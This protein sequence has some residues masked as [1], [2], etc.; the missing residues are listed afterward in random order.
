MLI[1]SFK[2]VKL[3]FVAATALAVA[4]F[5]ALSFGHTASYAQ[6]G[7]AIEMKFGNYAFEPATVTVPAGAVN[8]NINNPDSRRHDIV[9]VVNGEELASEIIESGAAGAWSVTLSAPGTYEFFC[10]IGNHRERG[11]VGSITVQ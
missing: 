5:V 3:G 8:F 9:I 7:A 10:S 1:T 4:A 6:E 2:R 11:M